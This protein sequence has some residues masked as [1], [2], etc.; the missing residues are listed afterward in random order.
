MRWKEGGKMQEEDVR[1][2][3]DRSMR[4]KGDDPEGRYS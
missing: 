4:D 1:R 3:E 2:E